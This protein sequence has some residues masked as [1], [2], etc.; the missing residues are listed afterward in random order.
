MISYFLYI[1]V[2]IDISCDDY[3]DDVKLGEFN[4]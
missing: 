2:T 1:F 3:R 4:T